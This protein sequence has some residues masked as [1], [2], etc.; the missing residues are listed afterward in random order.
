MSRN[1]KTYTE[2]F[3]RTLV[4][5]L[6]NGKTITEVSREYGIAT[7][8]LSGWRK[9]YSNINTGSEENITLA[10]YKKMQK[11][12]AYLKEECDILKK[13]LRIFAKN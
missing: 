13:A 8:N 5:L 1:N 3:K 7:S 11:D 4:D 12:F 2:E 10:D 9:M 6:N